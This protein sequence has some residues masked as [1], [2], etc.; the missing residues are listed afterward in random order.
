[1]PVQ[2]HIGTEPRKE[3]C[4]PQWRFQAK[5]HAGQWPLARSLVGGP[6]LACNLSYIAAAVSTRNLN[7][8]IATNKLHTD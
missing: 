1:M 5:R 8:A 6:W 4:L 2:R 3:Q 7:Y